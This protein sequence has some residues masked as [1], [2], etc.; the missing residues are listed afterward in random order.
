M[1]DTADTSSIR[2]KCGESYLEIKKDRIELSS[3][4]IMIAGNDRRGERNYNLIRAHTVDVGK[5]HRDA[6]GGDP[7]T[8]LELNEGG[9]PSWPAATS[10]PSGP[11]RT[12]T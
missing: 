5:D 6:G 7:Q 2:L 10:S 9:A 12:R 8:S 3:K 11:S 1:D 4:E